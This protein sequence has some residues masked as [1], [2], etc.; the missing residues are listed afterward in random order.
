VILDNSWLIRSNSRN[1]HH[2]FPKAYLKRIG[3]LDI[4]NVLANI[5]FVD[6][7][8]NKR[9]IG[10]KSPSQYLKEFQHLNLNLDETLKSHLIDDI[11]EFG[12]TT[13]NYERFLEKRTERIMTEIIKRI[14][15]I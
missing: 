10:A 12:I 11:D 2:F 15:E 9:E 1:Y 8:L 3:K 13:D 6:D 7:Y 5:T 14:G 4:A